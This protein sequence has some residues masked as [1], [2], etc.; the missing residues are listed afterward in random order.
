MYIVISWFNPCESFA[1]PRV[2]RGFSFDHFVHFYIPRPNFFQD[3]PYPKVTY[4]SL[5]L[6]GINFYIKILKNIVFCMYLQ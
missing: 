5:E 2:I 3:E 1:D 6:F 4:K